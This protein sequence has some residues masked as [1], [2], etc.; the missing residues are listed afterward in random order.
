MEVVP[1]VRGHLVIPVIKGNFELV[2]TISVK[3]DKKDIERLYGMADYKNFRNLK[4]AVKNKMFIMWAITEFPDLIYKKIK[5]DFP[6]F[7]NDND[8]PMPSINLFRIDMIEFYND[9]I[10]VHLDYLRKIQHI[11]VDGD[12]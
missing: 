8:S 1:I 10:E 3:I 5:N 9:E 12:E 4:N 6:E 11:N 7:F 2:D